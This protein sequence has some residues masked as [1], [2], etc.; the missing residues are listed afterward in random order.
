MRSNPYKY[1]AA[2]IVCSLILTSAPARAVEDLPVAAGPFKPSWESLAN[3]QCPE[4]FRDA[5]FGIW[6]HWGPQCEPEGGDWYARD[7]YIEGT[8]QYKAHV[9]KYGH[10]SEFGFKDVCNAWKADRFDPDRLIGLYKKAGAQYFVMMANHHDNFDNWNS[11]YQPWNSVNIGPK[12]DLVGLWEKAARKAGMHFGVS[13]HASRAWEWYEVSQL[14]D[15]TGP[16]A[17]VPYDG[18]LT[19]A[20]GQGKWWEGLDPQDLYAQNHKTSSDPIARKDPNR[21]PGDRPSAAYCR[22]F[23]DRMMDLIDS[24]KPDL[25]CFDD[26]VMPV[27]ED[28]G[29]SIAAHFYNSSMQWH[30][31]RNEAVM[32]TKKLNEQQKKCLVLDVEFGKSERIEPLAWQTEFC[33]GKWHYNRAIYEKHQYKTPQQIIH[34]LVDIVSKNG[35][36]LLSIPVRGNGTLDEDEQAF[37]EG[38][39]AWMPVNGEAI[40]GTRPWTIAGE[41][42]SM[43]APAETNQYGGVKAIGSKPCTAEDIRFTTKAGSLYAICLGIPTEPVRIKSLAGH[44]IGSVKLLGSD[45]KLNWKQEADALVIQPVAA[46]PCQHAVSFKIEF[47]DVL[48]NKLNGNRRNY[49]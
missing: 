8:P 27:N 49:E 37:L 9:A 31:G 14:S 18:N 34:L 36:L 11:K 44:K 3:Y 26:S 10:P 38:M 22:K 33:I 24:Y 42:P 28:C 12:K 43:S 21:I 46:W 39:A 15:K 1:I 32:D 40:F 19:K 48:G 30:N 23:Y 16:K 47:V 5:K 2:G 45:T 35:N 6:A 4:W 20:D 13:V 7:M 29:L 25:L 17:G 41:G